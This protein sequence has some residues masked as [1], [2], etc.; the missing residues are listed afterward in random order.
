MNKTT[1]V[2]DS[3]DMIPAEVV[4]KIL[5]DQVAR[6]A[7]TTES[8]YWFFHLYFSQYVKYPTAEFQKEMFTITEDEDIKL[9]IVVAFRGSGKSTIMTMSYPL[10]AI[11]GKQQKK[12][13]VILSQTQQQ[14]KTHMSNVKRELESNDLLRADLGPLQEESDEWGS[15][16]L[17]IPRFNAKIIAASS[18][19]SIRGLRHGAHRPDLIICDDVE[20]LNSVKTRD[21]RNKTYAWLT[22][23]IFPL[24]DIN[25]KITMVGNLL[26]EDSLLM[27]LKENIEKGEIDAVYKEYPL[28]DDDGDILWKGKYSTMDVVENEKKL[29]GDDKAWQREYMLKIIADEDQ[30]VLSEWIHYF[31]ELP[32]ASSWETNDYES[33]IVGVDLAISEKERADYTAIVTAH[34]FGS[35]EN[36]KVYIRPNPVNKRM[37]F[38]ASQKKIEEIAKT[39]YFGFDEPN[40]YIE[41]VAFQRSAI[42]NLRKNGMWRVKGFKVAGSDKR[43]RLNGVT[44]LLEG[45]HVLFPRQ[46][47]E[48][49]IHQL[50]YF[51]AE[52]HD[53]LVDAFVIVLSM[54]IKN[55]MH[56]VKLYDAG[57]WGF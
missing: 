6:R 42:Q 22:G 35:H 54:V 7:I 14:A 2:H 9:S 18:E 20:D 21:S 16:S 13:V 30:I 40:V 25:T 1:L 43:M 45:G 33:T 23:E 49:L 8:H 17:V 10:W 26:H 41:D 50:Q 48:E 3:V 32:K 31:D 27:R 47:C 36:L 51:G 34:V 24:G 39:Q 37:D 29:N 56:V 11:L 53:D 28:L 19:Q 46:G 57:I 38:P 52:K 12:C 5:S 4:D 44:P 15:L 55:E